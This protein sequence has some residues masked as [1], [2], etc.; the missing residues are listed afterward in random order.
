MLSVTTF[1][2]ISLKVTRLV[3]ASGR[4]SSSFRCQEMASPSRSGSVARYTFWLASAAS[5][6]SAMVSSFPLMGW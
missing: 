6:S 2:V 3:L 1:F 4:S 5:F